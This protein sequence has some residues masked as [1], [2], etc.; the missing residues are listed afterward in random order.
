MNKTVA[1]T[2]AGGFVGL[3]LVSELARQG[4]DIYAITSHAENI[5]ESS[6]ITTIG[7]NWTT[8]GIKEAFTQAKNAALWIHAAARVDLG[9]RDLLAMYH[10]NT[11]ITESLV[12]GIQSLSMETRLIYLSTVSVY[13]RGQEISV[14]VEP[15]PENHYGLSKLLGE[16][17]CQAY[18]G[19]NCLVLRLAGVWGSERKPK[20][21]INHC[22]QQAREGRPLIISGTG[23]AARNYLWVGDMPRI[24]SLAYEKKWHRILLAA[25][26][27]LVSIHEM[28]TAIG[29]K[30]GVPVRFE[31]KGNAKSEPDIIV[32][33]LQG[34]PVTHFNDALD[35]EIG[36]HS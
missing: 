19:K 34:L 22:L 7:C 35:I 26:P 16:H 8:E 14:N 6:R 36:V 9:D 3:R 31:G 21:F 24:V 18:M 27:E 20:L 12:L 33:G 17:L 10:D 23:Q 1:I 32:N 28:V 15:R 4:W 5:P 25:G 30:F 2:G 13:N 29:A 11:L